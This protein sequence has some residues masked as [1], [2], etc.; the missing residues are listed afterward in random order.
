MK[1]LLPFGETTLLG[2]AIEQAKASTADEVITVLGANYGKIKPHIEQYRTTIIENRGWERGIGSSIATG[3]KSISENDQDFKAALIFLA[4]QPLIGSSYL[5]RLIQTFKE[6][7]AK[8]IATQ[9]PRSNGVPAVFPKEYF[10]ELMH[11]KEDVGAR[12]LLNKDGS[13][14]ISVNAGGKLF[15]IDTPE[16]YQKIQ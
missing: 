7:P 6:N 15:D 5:N 1:Q 10:E 16:D 9:Y 11:L 3:I 2:N 13:L 14:V 4:D 8:I 12:N